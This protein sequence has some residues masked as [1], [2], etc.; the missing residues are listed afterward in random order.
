VK[1]PTVLDFESFLAWKDEAFALWDEW[2]EVYP[3]VDAPQRGLIQEIQS[4]LPTT[5]FFT[6]AD[7][8]TGAELISILL[9]CLAR[10]RIASTDGGVVTNLVSNLPPNLARTIAG[11]DG[12]IGTESTSSLLLCHARLRNTSTD[13]GVVAKLVGSKTPGL[14]RTTTPAGTDGCIVADPVN[15]VAE[16]VSTHML[17]LAR[18]GIASTGP[19]FAMPWAITGSDVLTFRRESLRIVRWV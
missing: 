1:Q 15:S 7:G 2:A 5:T 13:G 11:T 8:C 4:E 3:D 19:F 18:M 10:L 17:R 12:C 16:Q 9:L 6:G 14:A